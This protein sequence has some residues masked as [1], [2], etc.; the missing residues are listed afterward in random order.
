MD[1]RAEIHEIYTRIVD[2]LDV[3]DCNGVRGESYESFE[4][5]GNCDC[6][7]CMLH[8]VSDSV[9]TLHELIE[10]KPE[11]SS[12][13]PTSGNLWRWNSLGNRA[14][15]LMWHEE[16]QTWAL[17]YDHESL[18]TIGGPFMEATVPG[19]PDKP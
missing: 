13:P 11:W 10:K 12:K 17:L 5:P 18:V 14:E 4:A 8:R 6:Q 15:L 1:N 16:T 3:G 7:L 9:W 19:T 2:I